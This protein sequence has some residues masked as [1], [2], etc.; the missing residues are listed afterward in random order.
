MYWGTVPL[1]PAL[2]KGQLYATSKCKEESFQV[3]VAFFLKLLVVS[4]RH[5]KPIS[6][7]RIWPTLSVNRD[8]GD[9]PHTLAVLRLNNLV[10]WC[11]S[12]VTGYWCLWK[13]AYDNF[14]LWRE[15]IYLLSGRKCSRRELIN[16]VCFVNLWISNHSYSSWLI[17]ASVNTVFVQ[18]SMST[19]PSRV[20]WKPLSSMDGGNS[21][22][23]GYILVFLVMHK[24]ICYKLTNVHA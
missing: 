4:Q 24:G 12:N 5:P 19:R 20:F 15:S 1:T 8:S 22:D 9:H 16:R 23:P 11:Q 21:P 6:H 7:Q 3:H 10:P 18:M 17:T 13:Q 14:K 2:F